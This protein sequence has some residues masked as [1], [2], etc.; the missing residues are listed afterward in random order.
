MPFSI[1]KAG[2]LPISFVATRLN[3]YKILGVKPSIV[4]EPGI[5]VEGVYVKVAP[6]KGEVSDN[7]YDVIAEPPSDVGTRKEKVIVFFVELTA[8]L[9]PILGAVGTVAAAP[10]DCVICAGIAELPIAFLATRLN[11]YEVL[12]DSPDILIVEPGETKAYCPDEY[13]A[14]STIKVGDSTEGELE[15]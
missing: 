9:D 15:V 5:R 8:G 10:V 2:E 14:E 11:V 13:V 12:D 1:I 3:L 4:T 7:V 6:E